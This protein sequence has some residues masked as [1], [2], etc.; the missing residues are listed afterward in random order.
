[1]TLNRLFFHFLPRFSRSGLLA[2]VL[3]LLF[4]ISIATAQTNSLTVE[5]TA[6][7]PDGLGYEINLSPDGKIVLSDFDG[8]EIRIYTADG[9]QAVIYSGL[10]RVSDARA[11]TNG[12]I[13]YIED[14]RQCLGELNPATGAV[15][16]WELPLAP[17]SS[18]IFYGT[19]LDGAGRVW[20]SDLANPILFRFDSATTKVCAL[21]ASSLTSDGGYYLMFD[22]NKEILWFTDHTNYSLLSFNEN[23]DQLS[24]YAVTDWDFVIEGIINDEQGGVWFTDSNIGSIGHLIRTET[25]ETLFRYPIPSDDTGIYMLTMENKRVWFT[26]ENASS[27]TVGVLD[28]SLVTVSETAFT[29]VTQSGAPFNCLDAHLKVEFIAGRTELTPDWIAS[30]YEQIDAPQ[31]WSIFRMLNYS[32]PWGIQYSDGVLWIVDQGNQE[33]ARHIFEQYVYIPLINR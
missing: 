4:T 13:W 27:G 15:K 30:G 1:M 24:S 21:D 29:K 26:A 6:L 7:N 2:L 5:E 10:G 20:V 12:T 11:D 18:N 19:T 3:A 25:E 32:S 28:P 22:N 16:C 33:L 9:S 8:G 14:G 31:G 17:D 23:V